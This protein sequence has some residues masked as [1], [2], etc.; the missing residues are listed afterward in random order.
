M[1]TRWLLPLVATATVLVAV[2]A[3]ASP[4]TAPRQT[5]FYKPAGEE[6][7]ATPQR[8]VSL[9][10]V[11]TETLFALGV[12]DR[13]VGV[14]RYCDRPAAASALP[15]VGGFID[16]QL[17]AILALKPDLVVS[18]PSKGV[19][20][21]LDRLRDRGVPVLVG[22]GDTIGE[23]R[24]LIGGVGRAVGAPTTAADV[25]KAFDDALDAHRRP[26][27]AGAPRVLVLVG[28][29][30]LIA[31]GPNTFADEAVRWVGGRRALTDNTPAWPALSVEAISALAPDVIV[32]AGGPGDAEA[33]ARALAP[34]G[35][36]RPPIVH[37]D[38]ALLMRPGP[39]L[40]EDVA[41]LARLL[42]PPE[43]RP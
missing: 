3:T 30:P 25:L 36:R 10:P 7:S 35:K 16:P 29:R 17:E 6:V 13:V 28:A 2:L 19:R 4:P 43:P 34:L 18:M 26:A 21:T 15:K 5:H 40:H 11:V 38:D 9:A 14:T 41:Q 22:F 12:G 20:T 1:T 24:D 31:A 27:P 39:S 33:L 42:A 32:A 8:I 37:G 23:V